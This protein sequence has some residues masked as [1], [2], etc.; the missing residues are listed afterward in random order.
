MI[1]VL[2]IA[3]NEP[4]AL[5]EEY[6]ILCYGRAK[7]GKTSLFYKLAKEKYGDLSKAL[8]IGFEDGYKALKG[9]HAVSIEKWE[10]YL[11]LVNQLVENYDDVT[12]RWLGLDTLD[13]LYA[14]ASEYVVRKERIARKDAKI[15]TL[16]DIPWGGGYNL[17][18][19]QIQATMSKLIKAG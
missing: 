15:K 13:R 2:N 4:K 18:D 8:L 19:E 1:N 17:A 3:P 12:Y 14:L 11:D 6:V 16:T 7:A 5:L 10:D 9:I